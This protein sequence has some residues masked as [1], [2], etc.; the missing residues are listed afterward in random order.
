MKKLKSHLPSIIVILV[1]F[2]TLPAKFTRSEEIQ[3]VFMA[4]GQGFGQVGERF[5][6]I[7][8]I[9]GEVGIYT[10]A[11][12]ETLTVIFLIAGIWNMRLKFYGAIISTI[13]LL[14]ALYAHLFTPL[15]V[16]VAG[17]NGFLFILAIIASIATG[18]ILKKTYKASI[19][20]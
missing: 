6:S 8:G 11:A 1:F 5:G 12:L 3:E 16:N 17:D 15:G 14:G 9:F 13:V 2:Y 4:T 18:F 20:S 7:G 10:I 19:I